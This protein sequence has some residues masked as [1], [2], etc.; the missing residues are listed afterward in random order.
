MRRQDITLRR[1]AREGDFA[2]SLELARRYFHGADGFPRH[3][4]M[5]LEYLAPHRNVPA[6][7]VL[8]AESLT[9]S[10]LLSTAQESLLQSAAT[11]SEIARVK[12]AAWQCMKGDLKGAEAVLQSPPTGSA[13][14]KEADNATLPQRVASTLRRLETLTA[15]D[16]PEVA[17]V[18]ARQALA[19][20]N[21]GEAS[22]A[23]TVCSLIDAATFLKRAKSTIWELVALSEECGMPLEG[24]AST[25]VNEALEHAGAQ[26]NPK[27][28]FILGRALCA[29]PCGPN[30][31][32]ALVT[33]HNMRRG[34]A[35]LLRAGDAGVVEAWL[36]LYTLSSNGRSS[37]ANPEMARFCLGKAA[38]AGFSE[39]QRRLG[40]LILRESTSLTTNEQAI[41]LLHA[42]ASKGDIHA[43]VLL[44]SLVLPVGG[45]DEEASEA[46]THIR[47]HDRLLAASL[48]LAREFGLTRQE[49][50]NL[51]LTACA[52]EWGLV[53]T[54][55]RSLQPRLAAPRAIPALTSSALIKLKAAGVMMRMQASMDHR[56]DAVDLRGLLHKLGVADDLFFADGKAEARDRVRIGTRWA[57]HS[58]EKLRA[59]L[60]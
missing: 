7:K 25:A 40:A 27:A 18:V 57:H 8:V 35:L 17:I 55:S 52:R 14:A 21:V 59:A 11:I 29:I 41:A 47:E 60:H 45:S 44:R 6:A 32:R 5:G 4:G 37:V 36:H 30:P 42:S 38:A 43:T 48:D 3:V 33:R 58:G 56:R 46:L 13:D 9:L 1:A 51:D 34:V 54:P 50:S 23:L 53:T 28:W 49:W 16:A 19:A 22:F 2:A 15:I 39:A 26:D 10:E 24:L 31:A 12:W 20:R